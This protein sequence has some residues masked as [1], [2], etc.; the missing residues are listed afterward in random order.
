MWYYENK[1]DD[2]EFID[3]L[4]E[5]AQ[6]HPTRGFDNYYGR[7]RNEGLRWNRKRVLRIYRLMLAKLASKT[8]KEITNPGQR[9]IKPTRRY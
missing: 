9:D 1:R 8:K 5:L 3:K 6:K 4:N 7:I 2:K